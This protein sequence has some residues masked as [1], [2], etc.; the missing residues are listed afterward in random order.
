MAGAAAAVAGLLSQAARSLSERS[1]AALEGA[2]A[3][4]EGRTAGDGGGASAR[5][6]A[7]AMALGALE[8][9]RNGA[10]ADSERYGEVCEAVRVGACERALRL[11]ILA[12]PSY[13]SSSD[14]EVQ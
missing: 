14:D 3:T 9:A 7:A 2:V 1:L 6:S 4:A 5:A 13:T 10:G 11:A 12:R 8:V